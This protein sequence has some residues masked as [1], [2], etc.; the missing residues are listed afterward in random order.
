ML[1]FLS[2]NTFNN[3]NNP[4]FDSFTDVWQ[5]FLDVAKV[6]LIGSYMIN[7]K[8]ITKFI[9]VSKEVVHEKSCFVLHSHETLTVIQLPY[10]LE[11]QASFKA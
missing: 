4:S 6:N 10:P 9:T 5:V 7:V 11:N 2:E 8:K 1:T 3:Y